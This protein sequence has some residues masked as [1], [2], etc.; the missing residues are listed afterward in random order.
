[1]GLAATL[2]SGRVALDTAIFIYFIEEHQDFLPVIAPIFEETA[3]GA[4]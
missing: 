2:G 4:R 3:R 1:V